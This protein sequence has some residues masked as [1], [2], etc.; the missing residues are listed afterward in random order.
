MLSE[1]VPRYWSEELRKEYDT[2]G[3]LEPGEP[4]R[5]ERLP[6]YHRGVLREKGLL[7]RDKSSRKGD[8]S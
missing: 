2:L 8:F 4:V 3:Y 6:A 7:R 1:N 5:V